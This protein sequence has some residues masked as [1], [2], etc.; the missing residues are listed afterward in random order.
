MEKNILKPSFG[1]F[2]FKGKNWWRNLKDLKVYF[3]RRKF[4]RKNGYNEPLLW[5]WSAG[6]IA[7]MREVLDYY[8]HSA[9]SYWPMEGVPENQQQAEWNHLLDRMITL[10]NYM[11]ET[12][13]IYDNVEFGEAVAMRENS[14]VEFFELFCRYFRAFWD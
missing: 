14:T 12:N 9:V 10:L 8:R 3:K 7:M 13:P 5:D 2:G 4:L 1:L 6:F 11:D